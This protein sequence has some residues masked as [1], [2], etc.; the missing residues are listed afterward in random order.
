MWQALH[1]IALGPVAR[2]GVCWPLPGARQIGARH[3]RESAAAPMF[4]PTPSSA[5]NSFSNSSSPCSNAS[6]NACRLGVLER[7]H[8]GSPGRCAGLRW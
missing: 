4:A 7:V 8:D 3:A 1:V 2:R 5:L 6:A